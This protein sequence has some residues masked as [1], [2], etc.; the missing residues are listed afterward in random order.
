MLSSYLSW[1][2]LTSEQVGRNGKAML[3]PFAS[4]KVLYN[5]L[6]AT[7]QIPMSTEEEIFKANDALFIDVHY[8]VTTVNSTGLNTTLA[9]VTW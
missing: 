4:L 9:S 6:G 7:I 8:P 5:N 1:D 2:S 3:H